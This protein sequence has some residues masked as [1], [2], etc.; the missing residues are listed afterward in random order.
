MWPLRKGFVLIVSVFTPFQECTSVY[1]Y[2]QCQ[3]KHH[4][5]LHFKKTASKSNDH[6]LSS[7]TGPTLAARTMAVD[8]KPST[9][10]QK[11]QDDLSVLAN[12]TSASLVFHQSVLVKQTADIFLLS[13][14]IYVLD[15]KKEK[16]LV[17]ALIY[18]CSQTPFISTSLI[19]RLGLKNKQTS[20]PVSSVGDGKV[21]TF[22]IR[23]WMWSWRWPQR[24][25][26]TYLHASRWT[27]L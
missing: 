19:K 14:M 20:I 22:Q 26:P 21:A 7:N 3:G 13:A 1:T 4:T 16:V 10:S 8:P 25:R 12:G 5:L 17:R 6:H 2:R 15:K 24:F 18:R 23:L 11:R 27:L 9:W